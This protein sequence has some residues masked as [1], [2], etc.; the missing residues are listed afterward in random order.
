VSGSKAH[1]ISPSRVFS[2]VVPTGVSDRG[3]VVPRSRDATTPTSIQY[4]YHL[5]I[6]R[7]VLHGAAIGFNM[8][9]TTGVGVRGT[10][11]IDT[12]ARLFGEDHFAII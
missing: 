11:P 9:N 7:A 12:S 6:P 3:W 10:G 8:R 4:L 1:P 5:H 2:A